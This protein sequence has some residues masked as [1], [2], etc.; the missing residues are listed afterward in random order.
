MDGSNSAE[1]FNAPV[2]YMNGRR[3]TIPFPSRKTRLNGELNTTLHPA[4]KL[5]KY[6]YKNY[7]FIIL[8]NSL[9]FMHS[10]ILV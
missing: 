6:L 7:I 10:G 5:I 3:W 9:S 4:V 1:E 2:L 8:Y